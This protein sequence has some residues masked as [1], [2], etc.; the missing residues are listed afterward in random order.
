LLFFLHYDHL[1]WCQF[2]LIPFV[3]EDMMRHHKKKL[4]WFQ[5]F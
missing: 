4:E 3:F 2:S 1:Y 5:N